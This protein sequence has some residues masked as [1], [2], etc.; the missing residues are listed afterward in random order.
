MFP[1]I[2]ERAMLKLSVVFALYITSLLASNTLGLKIVPL[3]G[4]HIST[5]IFMFPFVFITTD[6]I[7]EVYGR[8][9][10]R[11]FVL[12]GFVST[13]LFIAYDALSLL[14]PWAEAGMWAKDSYNT[15]FGVSLRIAIASVVAFVVGEYQDV[16]AFFF[17][18][19]R[20]GEHNFWLRSNISNLWSQFLDT[21]LFM[22]IA[23]YGVY[24]NDVLIQ[25]IFT[26]WL[27]KVAM[28]VVYTPL[29]YLGIYFLRD[30]A[31]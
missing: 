11:F 17:V 13:L 3:L 31:R 8:R 9:M 28:G 6:V 30:S 22:T 21:V 7:G 18:R 1:Q 15:I 23:F 25:L 27:F 29:S 24:A 12:A 4:T 26:W 2:S 16:I 14:P 10:A 19:D 5:G 20:L